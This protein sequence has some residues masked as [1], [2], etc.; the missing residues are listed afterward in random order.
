MAPS[1]L[2]ELPDSTTL[3]RSYQKCSKHLQ[4]WQIPRSRLH[5][6]HQTTS[7]QIPSTPF[8][9]GTRGDD[10]NTSSWH[11]P[12]GR[13]E[14]GVEPKLIYRP[15][16]RY[17]NRVRHS[18]RQR[19]TNCPNSA[20]ARGQP[21]TMFERTLRQQRRTRH[22]ISTPSSVS[23]TISP[24][25]MLGPHFQAQFFMTIKRQVRTESRL[26]PW[27]FNSQLFV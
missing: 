9:C 1:R 11:Q 24:S 27:K 18:S 17:T 22:S 13:G 21:V 8:S 16:P 7:V 19:Q 2:V 20:T 23:K 5:R 26:P 4:Y 6:H 12:E 25:S 15:L 14:S 3:F 10:H